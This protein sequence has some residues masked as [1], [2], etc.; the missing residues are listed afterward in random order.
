MNIDFTAIAPVIEG[1][2]QKLGVAAEHLWGVLVRQ[3]WVVGIIDIIGV[4]IGLIFIGIGIKY[5]P[6]LWKGSNEYKDLS[7]YDVVGVV[8][9]IIALA[10]LIIVP[11]SLIS[12]IMHLMNPEY[13]A[14][15]DIIN[16]FKT[17]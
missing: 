10:S 1:I 6:S 13:Y 7:F 2:A 9:T 16:Q 11:L 8:L 5:I 3:A 14:F 17:K 12:G 15:T 4:I